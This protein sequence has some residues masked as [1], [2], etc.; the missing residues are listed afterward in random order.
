MKHL[1]SWA[2]VGTALFPS[3]ANTNLLQAYPWFS[4]A[5]VHAVTNELISL[6]LCDFNGHI[7]TWLYL[8]LSA[9]DATWSESDWLPPARTPAWHHLLE[10]AF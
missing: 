2:S 3:K 10:P 7:R 6:A 8:W 1:P 5:R 4:Y 9:Q